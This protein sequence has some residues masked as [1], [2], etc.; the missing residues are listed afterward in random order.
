M[1]HLK[2]QLNCC[3]ECFMISFCLSLHVRQ[4]FVKG[5]HGNNSMHDTEHPAS[6]PCLS[7]QLIKGGQS[8]PFIGMILCS[9]TRVH[10][11]SSARSFPWQ[12][13][14]WLRHSLVCCACHLLDAATNV[15]PSQK[16]LQEETAIFPCLLMDLEVLTCG[17]TVEMKYK[18]I[19]LEGS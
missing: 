11:L 4:P 8:V 13:Q 19:H 7:P 12:K 15:F 17:K 9:R 18:H 3:I 2:T 16:L 1:R 5:E 14:L 6:W 10:T